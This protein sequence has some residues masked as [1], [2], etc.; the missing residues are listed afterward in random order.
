[1]CDGRKWKR[2][3]LLLKPKCSYSMWQQ[4][5]LRP[6]TDRLASDLLL[7][8]NNT[9][10]VTRLMPTLRCSW[11]LQKE[12]TMFLKPLCACVSC[13]GWLCCSDV[14]MFP[15]LTNYSHFTLHKKTHEHLAVVFSGKSCNWH[16]FPGQIKYLLVQPLICRS[17]WH[18]GGH[19]NFR[20]FSRER[21]WR[22]L[23]LFQCLF[24]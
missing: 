2:Q 12:L 3:V 13:T 19:A 20:P 9:Q 6:C 14:S 17:A 5:F 10:E 18:P 22:S 4:R 16:K 24:K 11:K 23:K 8:T 1:M 21:L 7:K 15:D